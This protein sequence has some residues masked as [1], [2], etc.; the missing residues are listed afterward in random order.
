MKIHRFCK[1]NQLWGAKKPGKLGKLKRELLKIFKY[2]TISRGHHW[3]AD[4][5][6]FPKMWY[7]FSVA[8]FKGELLA[9][10]VKSNFQ[11]KWVGGGVKKTE[12]P[13]F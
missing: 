2:Y 6:R 9:V 13:Q 3:K 4:V 11:K 10:K 8:V 7:F 1:G 12:L 5:L